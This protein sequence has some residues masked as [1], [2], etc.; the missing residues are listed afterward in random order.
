M[1]RTT[2]SVDPAPQFPVDC[3]P[4]IDS[5]IIE[6]S[7]TVPPV[8]KPTISPPTETSTTSTHSSPSQTH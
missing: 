7:T 8:E 3:P 1:T 5:P 4:N 2:T 6:T